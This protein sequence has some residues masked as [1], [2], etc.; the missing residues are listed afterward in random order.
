MY[1]NVAHPICFL[2]LPMHAFVYEVQVEMSA[3]GVDRV[4]FREENS[5]EDQRAGWD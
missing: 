1:Q 3:Q 5:V 2:M 4:Y